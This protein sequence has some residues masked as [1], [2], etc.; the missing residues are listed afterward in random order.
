MVRWL[1]W[2]LAQEGAPVCVV[3]GNTGRAVAGATLEAWLGS[4]DDDDQV[5]TP[6]RQQGSSKGLLLVVKWLN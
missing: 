5:S 3:N 4:K 2:Q 1:P 6:S